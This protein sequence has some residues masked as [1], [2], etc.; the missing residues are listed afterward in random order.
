MTMAKVYFIN[1]GANTGDSMKARSPIFDNGKFR[2]VT[3]PSKKGRSGERPYPSENCAF[4]HPIHNLYKTHLDPDL[5]NLTY[6]DYC[7]NGRARA[8]KR[9]K[10]DDILL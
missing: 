1:V 9:V 10:V 4:L 6:G 8:L 5:E 2:F 7:G 3:F